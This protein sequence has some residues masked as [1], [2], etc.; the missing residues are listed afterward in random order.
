MKLR[1]SAKQFISKRCHPSLFPDSL[2]PPQDRP[3]GHWSKGRYF[4]ETRQWLTFTQ[5]WSIA[6]LVR[7]DNLMHQRLTIWQTRPRLLSGGSEVADL[8][9]QPTCQSLSCLQSFLNFLRSEISLTR[10]MRSHMFPGALG[11]IDTPGGIQSEW[12]VPPDCL[13]G[14]FPVMLLN[15]PVITSSQV[16]LSCLPRAPVWHP[17]RALPWVVPLGYLSVWPHTRSQTT[18]ALCISAHY[19]TQ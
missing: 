6:S 5:H 7:E 11:S 12:N 8:G 2:Y 13:L 15:Q 17:M 1:S 19:S 4:K 10:E 9:G 14:K 16:W 18:S 3:Q